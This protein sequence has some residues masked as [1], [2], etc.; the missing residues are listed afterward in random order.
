MRAAASSNTL[1]TVAI[2]AI[3]SAFLLLSAPA[4]ANRLGRMSLLS[5]SYGALV[6]GKPHLSTATCR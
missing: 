4:A 3:S 5:F 2:F 6:V 1:G